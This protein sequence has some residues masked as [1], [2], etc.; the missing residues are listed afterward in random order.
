MKRWFKYIK[1]Y[2]LF[3]ILGPLCMIIESVG[4]IF[5]PLLLR[6]I[7]Q[8][9]TDPGVSGSDIGYI[10]AVGGAM[11]ALALVM[12][13]GGIGGAYF[14]AKA[15]VNFAADL[16]SDIYKKI[17]KFSF[18]NIDKFSTG[19]LVTRLTNDVTQLQ[20]FV[21]M[22]VR[23]CLRAPIMLIGALIMAVSL[24]VKLSS[25]LAIA[26]PTLVI[27]QA[28]IIKIGFSRFA[29]VQKKIDA[30]N[31][32]VQE[33][34]TNV[35][36]VKSFV[37]EDYEKEKFHEANSNLKKASVSATGVMIF[38]HP[39][40][41]IIMNVTTMAVIVIGSRLIV[42]NTGLDSATLGTFIT[43][44]NQI[45]M[46]LMFVTMIFMN[47]SR[48]LASAKRICEVLDEK[49]DITDDGASN[50]DKIVEKGKIEFRNVFY[51]YYKNSEEA[52]LKNIN[53]TI[54]AGSTVGI[55]GSTGC[56]KTTLVSMIPRLYDVDEGEVLVD[57]VDVRDYSLYNLREG[58]G[59]VLQKNVLFTG[60]IRQNLE[61]GNQEA[62]EEDIVKACES[63]QADKF[64]KN[65]T[66]GYDSQLGQGG[67]NVSGGQK[68]RL[69][70]ARTLLKNPKIIILDDSTSAVDTA[71][72]AMIRKAFREDIKD[73]TKIIIAQRIGSVIDADMI[74]VMN[75]GEITGIGTHSEL[76]KTNKE[77]Q[78]IYYSQV[79]GDDSGK[80][81]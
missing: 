48:A 11:V 22:L 55:V 67:S 4:E 13:A 25:A 35:R 15:S 49:I 30:L 75:E 52:V 80:N 62:T 71:T 6:L 38:M 51:R 68:Q 72:E 29:R 59:M 50:K 81:A 12:M 2:K 18:A 9:V 37:R 45:L 21:N 70:I 41:M 27:V 56:G 65:F 54:P 17:Q 76:L 64:I 1:P 42:N 31:S 16:R 19:S 23:M 28:V 47:S 36:V 10:A 44:I 77:Y 60:T 5:M 78:E 26:V 46:S 24:N 3:F 74:V 57:G 8:R 61:W 39:L 53:I 73:S 20:N 14:G 33:N 58:V 32:T 43:Y 40:M 69:C 63:A 66:D 34:V 79:G 7:T